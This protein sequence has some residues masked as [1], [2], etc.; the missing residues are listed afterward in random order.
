MG[1]KEWSM[2]G[3]IMAVVRMWVGQGCIKHV[4]ELD[5]IRS[6][7]KNKIKMKT[8]RCDCRR[9][10]INYLTNECIAQGKEW[11]GRQIRKL[12]ENKISFLNHYESLSLS[13][14]LS[15]RIVLRTTRIWTKS[16]TAHVSRRYLEWNSGQWRGAFCS[17]SIINLN[18]R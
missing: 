18:S 3:R 2:M 12:K 15:G 14:S 16:L 11:E 10:A 4:G 5:G 13:L 9:K 8:T 1:E 6:R 7:K 17:H